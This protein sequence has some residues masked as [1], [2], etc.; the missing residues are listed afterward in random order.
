MEAE[1]KRISVIGLGKLGLPWAACFAEKGFS[2]IGVDVDSHKIQAVNKGICPIYE[3]GLKE[4]INASQGRLTAT[5]DYEKAVLNCEVSFIFVPTPIDSNNVLSS[6]Y[7]L[8]VAGHIGDVLRKKSGYHLVV[9][10]S[11]VMPGTTQEELRPLLESS[12]GKYCGKDFGLCYNPEFV[13]LGSVLHDLLNPDF[14]LIGESDSQSGSMLADLYRRVCENSPAV[15]RM[16]FIN[17]ELTKLAIN[18]FVTTKISFAN[19]LARICERLPGANV[20]V[21]SSALGLDSRIGGKYLKGA[22]GYGGPCFPRVNLALTAL[23]HSLGLSAGLSQATD[24]FNRQQVPWLVEL[25]KNYLKRD[26]NVGILGLSYK[27]DSDV[28]EEAQGMLLAQALANDGIKV[29]AYDPVAMDKARKVL[30]KSVTFAKSVQ[31]CIQKADVV[32]IMTPWDEFKQLSSWEPAR[33]SP[34][35][36]I[37]DCWR[38]LDKIR[39]DKGIIYVPLGVGD[40]NSR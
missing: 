16:N 27:P 14:V 30:K 38:I 25:I 33:T 8:E 9:L 1:L 32:V 31:D 6:Q 26:S 4:L 36:V 3:P 7:I 12:S 37:V 24:T 39:Q 11:T 28:V 2:V 13:A 23:L 15:A 29:F 22:I 21:V 34:P 18:A 10:V 5:D 19:T 35:K 20:E 40:F 17:A